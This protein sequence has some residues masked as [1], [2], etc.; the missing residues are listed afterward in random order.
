VCLIAGKIEVERPRSIWGIALVSSVICGIGTSPGTS[1]TARD[2]RQVSRTPALARRLDRWWPRQGH[3]IAGA[4][5]V[6]LALLIV[7]VMIGTGIGLRAL[8]SGTATFLRAFAR[9]RALVVEPRTSGEFFV[10]R[11]SARRGAGARGA[12]LDC[13]GTGGLRR[14]GLPKM[15]TKKK[16]KKRR[17]TSK[18]RKKRKKS[19]RSIQ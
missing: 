13:A 3:R 5:V 12:S 9:A 18:K 19:T 10:R 8:Y 15:S 11:R 7:A 17:T 6:L 2:D 1:A 4:L 16:R 14:A